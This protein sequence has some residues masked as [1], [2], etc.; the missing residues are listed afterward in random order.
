MQ[1]AFIINIQFDT[2][3]QCKKE[4]SYYSW[5]DSFSYCI[6]MKI[7]Q[8]QL[9]FL[10]MATMLL[11]YNEIVD[12]FFIKFTCLKFY[13]FLISKKH[14][15]MICNR[16]SG[17]GLLPITKL[18]IT[19]VNQDHTYQDHICSMCPRSIELYSSIMPSHN[20]EL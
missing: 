4:A 6:S 18:N 3:P 5:V 10:W 11:C 19:V 17:L 12:I 1:I 8:L 16:Q 20:D 14:Q 13:H 2:Q 9:F 15:W 7:C